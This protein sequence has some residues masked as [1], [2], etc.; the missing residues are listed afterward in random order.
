VELKR[1][2]FIVNFPDKNQPFVSTNLSLQL[3]Q[4]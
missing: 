4:L 2:P 1:L 3:Q